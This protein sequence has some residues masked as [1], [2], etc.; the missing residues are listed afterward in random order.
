MYASTCVFLNK[1]IQIERKDMLRTC[2][3][4]SIQRGVKLYFLRERDACVY[5]YVYVKRGGEDI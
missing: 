4:T 1:R 5:I 2:I 3:R